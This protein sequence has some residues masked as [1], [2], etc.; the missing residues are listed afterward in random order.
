MKSTWLAQLS[1]EARV[2]RPS[3]SGSR[4]SNLM[5]VNG[6]L[7]HLRYR[8]RKAR[9]PGEFELLC[10]L[11]WVPFLYLPHTEPSYVVPFVVNAERSQGLTDL[12]WDVVLFIHLFSQ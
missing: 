1:W 7:L 11:L 3:V 9:E 2:G 6:L 5:A 4:K 12:G 10:L 8:L